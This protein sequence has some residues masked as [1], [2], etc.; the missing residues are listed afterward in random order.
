MLS[1]LK[2][3]T[4]RRVSTEELV[5]SLAPGK[6]GALK[7]RPDGTV[8]NGH[9]RITVLSERGENIHDLPRD[10]IEKQA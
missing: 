9:H 8:L 6:I 7:C 4:F 3:E 10:I 2:L 5:R 1:Q